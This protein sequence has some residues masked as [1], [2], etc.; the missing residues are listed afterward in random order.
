MNLL[1]RPC[2]CQGSVIFK[3]YAHIYGHHCMITPMSGQNLQV[4]KRLLYSTAQELLQYQAFQRKFLF[5]QVCACFAFIKARITNLP[6][7]HWDYHFQSIAH[8][9]SCF[10]M[11]ARSRS[12]LTGHR[13][14]NH[15]VY[16]CGK[17]SCRPRH[18]NSDNLPAEMNN[19]EHGVIRELTQTNDHY[20]NT[21]Q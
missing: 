5:P 1:C 11:M 4:E 15:G 19:S 8:W 20:E 18:S 2:S 7:L 16:T 10:I 17:Q 12:K 14:R 6:K 9:H 3:N 13:Q 21:T